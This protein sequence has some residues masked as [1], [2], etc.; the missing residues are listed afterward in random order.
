MTTLS[1]NINK[2]ATLRNQRRGGG[3][4]VMKFAGIALDAKAD[5]I[6]VHPRPDERHIRYADLQPLA[7]LCQARQ[8]EFNIEGNPFEGHWLEKV[9]KIRP[10][11][12]TLVPDDNDQITSDHGFPL[13]PTTSLGQATIIKLRPVVAKLQAAGCRVSLFVDPEPAHAQGAA[14][15]GADRIELYTEGWAKAFGQGGMAREAVLAAYSATAREAQAHG[16]GVN[17]GHDLNLD[18]L[19]PFL[20]GVP[21]V[22]EVSIGHALIADALEMGLHGAVR[23]YRAACGEESLHFQ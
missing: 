14:Q 20:A 4:S 17:A 10:A 21:G 6:T 16:L 15:T 7:D 9:L 13:D 8:V 23:H 11:Q 22:L 12:A 1:V 19:A 2:I 3:P 5:G 18:N